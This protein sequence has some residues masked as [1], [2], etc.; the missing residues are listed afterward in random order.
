L[1][2]LAKITE[3]KSPPTPV[4]NGCT[5]ASHIAIIE[6]YVALL[7]TELE[8]FKERHKSRLVGIRTRLEAA[9]EQMLTT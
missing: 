2:E 7:S 5:A 3:E 6:T 4:L 1:A 8:K 9:S